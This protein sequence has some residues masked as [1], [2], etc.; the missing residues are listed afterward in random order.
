MIDKYMKFRVDTQV[1]VWM[2]GCVLFS[3]C[4]NYHPY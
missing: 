2:V 4:F 1:D 3:L